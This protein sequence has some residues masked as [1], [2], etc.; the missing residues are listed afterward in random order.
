MVRNLVPRV[1]A[2]VGALREVR[3]TAHDMTSESRALPIDLRHVKTQKCK[4]RCLVNSLLL[5]TIPV[6]LLF[7]NSVSSYLL[8]P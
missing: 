7:L 6:Y 4:L 5:Q 1:C 8:L 3:Q 2:S